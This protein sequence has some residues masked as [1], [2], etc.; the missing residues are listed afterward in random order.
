[1]RP[2]AAATALAAGA[3]LDDVASGLRNFQ[4]AAGRFAV[5]ELAKG[6]RI[7]DDAYNAN[8]ASL[9]AAIDSVDTRATRAW[10]VM[11]Q[12]AELGSDT[13]RYHREAGEHAKRAGFERLFAVGANAADSVAGFGAGGEQFEEHQTLTARLLH[14]VDGPV[15]I[16]VKGS[17]SAGLE[18]V[19]AAFERGLSGGDD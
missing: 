11:G 5:H 14:A 7:V 2:A 17:R 3:N 8:P 1:M 15:T 10:L 18:R 9:A 6:V 16:L 19:I 12:L 13:A 4:T